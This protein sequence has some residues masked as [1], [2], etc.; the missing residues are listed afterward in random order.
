MSKFITYGGIH[1]SLPEI[2]CV[3]VTFC[4]MLSKE[5]W[6]GNQRCWVFVL[7]LSLVIFLS[8]C[9]LL[10]LSQLSLSHLMSHLGSL[11]ASQ[12]WIHIKIT[13]N[14]QNIDAQVMLQIN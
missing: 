3:C 5:Q 12:V 6:T 11:S 2:T 1:S 14:A 7:A 10:H 13:R 9:E 8:W 4:L